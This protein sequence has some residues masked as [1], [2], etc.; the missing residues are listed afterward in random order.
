MK[1]YVKL[2]AFLICCAVFLSVI[3]PP[4]CL[5]D[6]VP[7]STDEIESQTE[8]IYEGDDSPDP[9]E[10]TETADDSDSGEET[11]TAP[12]S[13]PAVTT[14]AKQAAAEMKSA[15]S[16]KTAETTGVAGDDKWS[17][18]SADFVRWVTRAY[19]EGWAYVVGGVTVGEV[20]C[21]GLIYSFLKES[22]APY[23]LRSTYDMVCSAVFG[24]DMS[25]VPEIP[26]LVLYYP[27]H[28]GVYI[29]NDAVVEAQN[30]DVGVI[31]S[32]LSVDDRWQAWV[33]IPGLDYGNSDAV[34]TA[35]QYY[36]DMEFTETEPPEETEPGETA[37]TTAA[38]TAK[39][40]KE[41]AAEPVTTA[42]KK[43]AP[44]EEKPKKEKKVP[45]LRK[46]LP[47]LICLAAFAACCVTALVKT[48]CRKR[49][50]HNINVTE[51]EK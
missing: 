20:D 24:G 44:A 6:D 10:T 13:E 16:A 11:D 19:D 28:V 49:T 14:N 47:D 43:P 40:E 37:G 4:A 25:Y 18:T 27:G 45:F 42:Q 22:G 9:E 50:A 38:E 32:S 35:M 46:Y 41:T 15:K 21:S 31:I 17:P 1:I 3:L 36:F 23:L 39:A 51:K 5:A 12:E 30:E 34:Q 33:M 26:G 29:G 2:S 7:D 8:T 48:I